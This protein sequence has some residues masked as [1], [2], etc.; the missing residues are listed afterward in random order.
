[1]VNM[2]H[3]RCNEWMYLMSRE[4]YPIKKSELLKC[5][6]FCYIN[7]AKEWKTKFFFHTCQI[8]NW[9]HKTEKVCYFYRRI[10]W[11]FLRIIWEIWRNSCCKSILWKLC[12]S[13][14]DSCSGGGFLC[15]SSRQCVSKYERCNM[16]D[17]CLN[18]EDEDDCGTYNY[19]CISDTA[20]DS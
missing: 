15:N 3:F 7:Y 16:I 17:A 2:Y 9:K 5:Q 19:A 13:C 20:S 12:G 6:K 11:T 1:M 8:E 18:G 14:L 4:A 10:E